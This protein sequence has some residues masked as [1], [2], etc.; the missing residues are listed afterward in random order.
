M[1]LTHLAGDWVPS[2]P[3][4]YFNKQCN[5]YITAFLG[6]PQCK[7][8]L[9]D[10]Q[11]LVP[12][13]IFRRL[14]QVLFTVNA[15]ILF[16]LLLLSFS[17]AGLDALDFESQLLLHP[18]VHAQRPSGRSCGTENGCTFLSLHY[19]G[20]H[21]ISSIFDAFCALECSGQPLHNN[22][23]F[24][25]VVLHQ[26][27]DLQGNLDAA[28]RLPPCCYAGGPRYHCYPGIPWDA[29]PPYKKFERGARSRSEGKQVRIQRQI[30][31]LLFTLTRKQ[32]AGYGFPLTSSEAP[33][34]LFLRLS[35][36]FSPSQHHRCASIV[37]KRS[38]SAVR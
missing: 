17:N 29:P 4:T 9:S 15:L 27:N 16:F 10:Q 2:F 31:T 37:P 11:D 19:E 8:V 35:W 6:Q 14:Q 7:E 23:F 12:S 22:I 33:F 1:I 34:F 20:C 18:T 21:Q 28:F 38:H 25:I 3:F 5:V 24:N 32:L 13:T 30:P 36:F 26:V